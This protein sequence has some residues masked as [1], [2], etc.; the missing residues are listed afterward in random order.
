DWRATLGE[1]PGSVSYFREIDRRFLAAAHAFM[2][3]RAIPFDTEVP[4][5]ELA[6]KDVLEIGVGQ[7][8]HA[9]L[10]APRAR[11]FV[12]I[13]LTIAAAAM[14]RKRFRL[15]NIP[16]SIVQMDA[17]RMGFRAESFDYIWSWGV[18]HQAADTPRVLK[19][20][21]RVLRPGGTCTVMVYY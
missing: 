11:S 5:D 19:E 7:G 6:D 4:F 16:G 21:H 12:G 13:D 17:E 1:E 3:W 18:V 15:F 9:E 10:L 20:M 2:P 14:A 8:T